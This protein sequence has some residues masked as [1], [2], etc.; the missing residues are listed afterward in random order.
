MIPGA[1]RRFRLI[2]WMRKGRVA[3]LSGKGREGQG[4][5]SPPGGGRGM[6]GNVSCLHGALCCC[7]K[8]VHKVVFPLL[9]K[10]KLLGTLFMKP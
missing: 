1:E 4:S 5:C 3:C 6:C 7:L 10:S 9:I 2:M 8:A